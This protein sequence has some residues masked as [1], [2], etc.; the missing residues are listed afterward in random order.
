[1]WG[2][3]IK[4]TEEYIRPATR[5]LQWDWIYIGGMRGDENKGMKTRERKEERVKEVNIQ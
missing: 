4:C 5:R 3:D 2:V 1:M